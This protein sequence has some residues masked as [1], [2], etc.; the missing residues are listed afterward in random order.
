[1]SPSFSHADEHMLKYTLKCSLYYLVNGSQRIRDSRKEGKIEEITSSTLEFQEYMLDTLNKG[2]LSLMLSIGHR[3][4]LFDV[5]GSMD[6]PSTSQDIADKARLNERYVREW[7]GAMV[8]SKIVD[9][10]SEDKAYYLGGAK[11]DFL[12][13]AGEASGSYNF[14]SAMQWIPTC[15]KVEDQIV[16]CFEKGGGVPYSSFA[17]FH[18][19]M[20]EDSTQTVLA[21]LFDGIIP[22][23]KGLQNE[24]E[25][26]ISVLD[27][28]CG[29]GRAVNAMAHRFPR[30]KFTGYDISEEAIINA[31]QEA[32]RLVNTNVTFEVKDVS[33][34]EQLSISR[35]RKFDLVTAF[36]A[37][38]DQRDPASVLRNIANLL[39]PE[40]G[41]FLMQDI[42][43]S[44]ALENNI[45][46]PI[47]PFLYAVSCMHCMTVSLAEDGAGL[48]TVWGK[49]KAVEMLRDAGF[50][51]IEVKELPHDFQNYYMIARTKMK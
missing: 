26:G 40:T 9:Y 17:R 33:E 3:T 47:G 27:I 11:A 23:V 1:M 6:K 43:A 36:D 4:G 21:A 48:G 38:H 24:L 35:L 20:A 29:S 45:D 44:S 30:S 50:G 31:R 34:S 12:T 51:T 39:R 10:S 37:I 5:M 18:E 7:L 22:L 32:S 46:H 25:N 41:T 42:S 14:A 28:G 19:V 8:V 13:R 2:A 16:R 49:E 15:A